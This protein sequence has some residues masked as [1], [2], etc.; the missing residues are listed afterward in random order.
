MTSEQINFMNGFIIS[1]LVD[2]YEVTEDSNESFITS[3]NSAVSFELV[4]F[5]N[6]VITGLAHRPYLFGKLK[7]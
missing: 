1:F 3:Q 6:G 7:V 5:Q 4:D 2:G